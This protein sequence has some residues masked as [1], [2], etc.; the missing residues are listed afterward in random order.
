MIYRG[1]CVGGFEGNQVIKPK[2]GKQ[3]LY[4]CNAVIYYS[5]YNSG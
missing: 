2:T 5:G 3:L 1:G 4:R